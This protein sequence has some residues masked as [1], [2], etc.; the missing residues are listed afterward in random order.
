MAD[1]PAQYTGQTIAGMPATVFLKGGISAGCR[2]YR[3]PVIRVSAP[4]DRVILS[5]NGTAGAKGRIEFRVGERETTCVPL[6]EWAAPSAAVP[7]GQKFPPP[8]HVD[9]LR[10]GTAI[11]ELTIISQQHSGDETANIIRLGVTLDN[12][13]AVTNEIEFSADGPADF[14]PVALP[15]EFISQFAEGTAADDSLCCPTSATMVL[16]FWGIEAGVQQVARLAYDRR[17]QLYGN[18]SLTV[19]AMSS[20]GLR[21]WVQRHRSV[22]ELYRSVKAGRPVI[23]SLAFGSGGLPGAP[24]AKTGGHLL[25]VRG[26]TESGDVLVND[27]AGRTVNTGMIAYDRRAFSRAWLGHG[28][29]ALHAVPKE[30]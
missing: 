28:G 13:E 14:S 17:H 21:A 19:A 11:R 4:F 7:E 16:R 8:V 9:V 30:L 22:G 26:F 5:P 3:Y 18:W 24:I 27:P 25:V 20:Y 23:T 10:L 29:I 1:F 12:S 6:I 15:V 2:E